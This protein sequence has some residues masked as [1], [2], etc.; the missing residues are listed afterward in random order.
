MYVLFLISQLYF[1]C[2]VNVQ[3]VYF[4]LFFGWLVVGTRHGAGG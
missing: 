3:C 4:L 1:V 2:K